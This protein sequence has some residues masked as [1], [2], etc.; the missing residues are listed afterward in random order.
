ML[1]PEIPQLPVPLLIWLFLLCLA[2]CKEDIALSHR[3]TVE[4]EHQRNVEFVPW[5]S[6][7]FPG[8]LSKPFAALELDVQ[9]KSS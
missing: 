9:K 5:T 8:T 4:C 6:S 7:K 3:Q 1:Y 2:E